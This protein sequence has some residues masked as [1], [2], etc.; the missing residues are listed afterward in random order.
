[1]R[2]ARQHFPNRCET[3]EVRIAD[4]NREICDWTSVQIVVGITTPISV[5]H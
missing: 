5:H 1:M 4:Q 2:N 3:S